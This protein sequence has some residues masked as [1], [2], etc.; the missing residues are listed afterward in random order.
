MFGSLVRVGCGF[1]V[2]KAISRP[3]YL[4][5]I[6]KSFG[7]GKRSGVIPVFDI[8]EDSFGD[9][10]YGMQKFQQAMGMKSDR[11]LSYLFLGAFILL[12]FLGPFT[13]LLQ[14]INLPLHVQLG[15]SE[16][17]IL[18]PE[19]GWF[20]ADELAI[21]WA[22]MTYLIAGVIFIIGAFMRRS[23]SIF[24][25]LYTNAAWSFILLVAR[26]RWPLLEANGFDVLNEDQE[27]FFYVFATI[28]IVFGWFGMYYLW[29]N[30][31][32]FD[33]TDTV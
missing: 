14:I 33:E 2:C 6:E 12:W 24:F 4:G 9:V 5:V 23:W 29:K 10:F 15:L 1:F 18:E 19:F 11:Q 17:I 25:G 26:I 30:R 21:A 22:D 27:L 13:Q 3:A 20:K 7:P 28:Y 16:R 32:I 31:T 8:S